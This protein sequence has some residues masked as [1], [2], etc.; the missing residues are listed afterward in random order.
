MVV[1][2]TATS[3]S[4]E[5]FRDIWEIE[6]QAA[7]VASQIFIA[8]ANRVGRDGDLNFFGA[9]FVTD[10]FGRVIARAG[11]EEEA[12]L[13]A[14]IDYRTIEE[15]RRALPFL[16]D[17]RYDL[18]RP[19]SITVPVPTDSRRALPSKEPIGG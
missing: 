12:L 16:R 15:A 4:E 5:A 13:A 17:L 6:L 9:S 1:V 3:T 2:P 14:D 10:P 8:V 18:Y 19:G 11:G 7:A